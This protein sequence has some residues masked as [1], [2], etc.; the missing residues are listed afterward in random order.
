[1]VGTDIA[2]VGHVVIGASVERDPRVEAQ[3]GLFSP[4]FVARVVRAA[5]EVQLVGG[6]VP[7]V[8]DGTEYALISAATAAKRGFQLKMKTAASQRQDVEA[9][10]RQ[11]MRARSSMARST[12]NGN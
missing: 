2:T 1:M 10:A 8:V 3:G 11:R 12:R 6:D 7:Q 5:V 9:A 4:G